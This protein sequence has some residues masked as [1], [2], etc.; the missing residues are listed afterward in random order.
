MS[1]IHCNTSRITGRGFSWKEIL[2]T[3]TYG[4]LF[5]SSWTDRLVLVTERKKKTKLTLSVTN[6]V[7]YTTNKLVESIKYNSSDI[8][9]DTLLVNYYCPSNTIPLPG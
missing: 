1:R 7:L 4:T 6:M 9:L 3:L 2:H 5:L 8:G